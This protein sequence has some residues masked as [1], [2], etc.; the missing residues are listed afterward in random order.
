[1][2]SSGFARGVWEAL[3]LLLRKADIPRIWNPGKCDFRNFR[4]GILIFPCF[5][6]SGSYRGSKTVFPD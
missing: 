2:R 4:T 6:I 5:N 3:C 1:M